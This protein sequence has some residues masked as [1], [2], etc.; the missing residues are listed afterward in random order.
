[1]LENQGN[2]R[3]RVRRLGGPAG[4]DTFWGLVAAEPVSVLPTVRTAILLWRDRE[5]Q[6]LNEP[7]VRPLELGVVVAAAAAFG[8]V[9]G[10]SVAG[11][12]A[13]ATSLVFGVM[14]VV[15]VLHF[16]LSSRT[17]ALSAAVPAVACVAVSTVPMVRE[18]RWYDLLVGV[19]FAGAGLVAAA[20]WPY[21]RS[22][23]AERLRWKDPELAL[24]AALLKFGDR[25]ESDPTPPDRRRAVAELD[26]AAQRFELS[27]PRVNRTGVDITDRQLRAWAGRIRAETREL[28]RLFA[29][30]VP[31]TVPLLMSTYELIQAIVNRYPLTSHEEAWT[32]HGSW[33]RPPTST[34]GR[35][36]VGGRQF[37]RYVLRC[38][39]AGLIAITA[40][41]LL[42]VTV[43]PAV[44]PFIGTHV[45]PE[46]GSALSFDPTVRVFVAGISLSL[47]PLA[48][49]AFTRR[50]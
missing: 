2:L 44:P 30:G 13:S 4:Y 11:L 40:L 12:V 19:A 38:A 22:W 20:L 32:R 15:L 8:T 16:A 45:S 36:W 37:A 9:G 25:V 31:Q 18:T 42:A 48:A 50:R 1:M 34:I 28:Q 3:E 7:W 6:R 33:R 41:L 26:R 23:W 49:R 21:A 24:V 27:W 39:L 46:L 17:T 5:S 35:L 10:P 14:F 29:F 47:F 43:W